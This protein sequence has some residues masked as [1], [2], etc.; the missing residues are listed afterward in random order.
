MEPTDKLEL[1]GVISI[2]GALPAG[3]FVF[4]AGLAAIFR[5]HPVSI[6]RAVDRKELP[7]PSRLFGTSVWTAGAIVKHIE[8]RQEAAAKEAERNDRRLQQL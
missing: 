3:A 6:K 1:P 2:L 4:E 7:Q 8:S 5:K